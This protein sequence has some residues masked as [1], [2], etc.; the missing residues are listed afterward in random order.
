MGHVTLNTAILRRFVIRMLGIN[1]A[2]MYSKFD[3]SSLSHSR[4]MVG[5][6]QS[7]TGSE[8]VCHPRACTCYDHQPIYQI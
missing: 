1:I 3:H 8:M 6:H 5:P 4:D 7:L 2:Y